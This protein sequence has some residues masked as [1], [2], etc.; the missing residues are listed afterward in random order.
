VI[1]GLVQWE[2][3]KVGKYWSVW[4]VATVVVCDIKVLGCLALSVAMLEH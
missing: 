4:V 1:L 2:L 3:L